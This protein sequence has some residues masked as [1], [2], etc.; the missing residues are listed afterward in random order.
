MICNCIY[1]QIPRLHF[2]YDSAGNQT[3]RYLKLVSYTEKNTDSVKV[4]KETVEL[5]EKDLLKFLKEDTFS[6]YPNP[7]KE[8]LYLTWEL[9]NDNKL[10]SISV[11]SFT[12]Q[13]LKTINNL[14]NI[15]STTIPFTDFA[16]GSYLIYLN[17]T[18][19]NKESITILKQ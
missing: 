12:G 8:Q 10:I 2:N 7:V 13:H 15:K 11:F 18:N 16:T 9:I 3:K 6:Y 1:S 19:G 14:E 4:Y 17:Y 5:E